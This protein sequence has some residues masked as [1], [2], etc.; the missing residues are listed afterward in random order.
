M[1]RFVHTSD[2]HLGKR[3][4]Q[5]PEELRGR[6]TEARHGSIERLIA[7][8]RSRNA[9]VILV[10]GDVFDTETPSM[11]T[12]RQALQAMGEDPSVRWLLMPGN[13]DSLSAGE[14]WNE[15]ARARPD[16]VALALTPEPV[17]LSAGAVLLPAPCTTRRPGR[18]LTEWMAAAN[19]PSDTVRIGLAHGAV[20]SFGEEG[21]TDVIAPDR[22]ERAGL[23]YLALGDWHGQIRITDRTWY[24]GAPEPDRFKHNATGSALVVTVE[25]PGAV[26]DVTPLETGKFHWKRSHSPCCRVRMVPGV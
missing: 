11:G 7:L 4:G 26:P 13:H 5:M 1:I 25:G 24:S 21:A 6:L 12:V 17:E 20:Q 16:N 23:D 18:D 15:V 19:T 2:L 3:F 10:A 22:A 9:D 8:A 14:L